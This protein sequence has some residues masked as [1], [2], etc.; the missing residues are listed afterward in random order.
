MSDPNATPQQSTTAQ[1]NQAAA[2]QQ[3]P[4][5]SV[6]GRESMGAAQ[7]QARQ[8]EDAARAQAQQQ[9][10]QA[11]AQAEKTQQEQAQRQQ[12]AQQKQQQEK[13]RQEQAAIAKANTR[14]RIEQAEAD[15]NKKKLAKQQQ[16]K[17]QAD[18]KKQQQQKQ[19]DQK[20]QEEKKAEE[21]QQLGAQN[22]LSHANA[23]ST[24]P[25]TT[26][27][28][29]KTS[30]NNEPT[31]QTTA[32]HGTVTPDSLEQKRAQLAKL[33]MNKHAPRPAGH[34]SIDKTKQEELRNQISQHQEK[35]S[36]ASLTL[37]QGF[38]RARKR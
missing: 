15:L 30:F 35:L 1:F 26:V 19:D 8:Q 21:K 31:K 6:Q 9:Q 4:E 11:R 32:D 5:Q 20:K 34:T 36:K 23:V 16:E 12:E 18:Q 17:A 3:K 22:R 27:V 28:N 7:A 2:P 33:Q 14:K 10:A 13:R 29:V 24:N 25:I 37:R 38:E